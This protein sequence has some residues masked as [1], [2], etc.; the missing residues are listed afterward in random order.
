MNWNC[1]LFNWD[2]GTVDIAVLGK[3]IGGGLPISAIT[4]S[5]ARNHPLSSCLSVRF[6]SVALAVIVRACAAIQKAKAIT[7]RQ[8]TAEGIREPIL[9]PANHPCA[10]TTQDFALRPELTQREIHSMRTPDCE[11]VRRVAASHIDNVLLRDITAYLRC[12]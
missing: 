11:Q 6:G 7:K 2:C 10:D 1:K 3:A 12:V 9:K 8:Q 5:V 4:G